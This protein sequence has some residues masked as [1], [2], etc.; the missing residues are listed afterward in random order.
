[1]PIDVLAHNREVWDRRVAAGDQW[2]LP[3]GHEVIEAARRGVVRL[4]LTPSRYVPAAWYPPLAG[5]DVL[6]LASGGGQQGPIFAA[7]GAHVTV[8]DNSP[9]QL[10]RDREVAEREGLT[11]RTIEGDMADLSPLADASFDLIFHPVSNIFSREVRPV[12]REAH[13]VLRPGG[14]L[15]AGFNNP[16]VYIFDLALLDAERRLEVRYRLP[17]SDLESLSEEGLQAYLA[18]GW[19]LEFSHTLDDQI[20]GQLAAGLLLAG[21]YEDRYPP[22]EDDLLSEYMPT[23]FA[24][25]AIKLS[26]EL[27]T[28]LV[29]IEEAIR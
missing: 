10:G 25:R 21:F 27:P 16:D 4:L 11:I 14:A 7:A 19:P 6:C 12:W 1:M 26:D 13:R 22:Q 8:F 18:K 20:G 29:K 23:F 2:T 3:V 17:Y 28:R 5:A 15:L 24:T 9:L